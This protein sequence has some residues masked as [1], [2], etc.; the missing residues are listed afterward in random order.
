MT[1]TFVHP[2]EAPRMHRCANCGT[3]ASLV[4]CVLNGNIYALKSAE[5][6]KLKINV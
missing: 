3:D 1:K 4:M 2:G 6:A 5:K